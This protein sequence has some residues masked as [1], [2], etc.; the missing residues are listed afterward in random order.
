[1]MRMM[2]KEFSQLTSSSRELNNFSTQPE[3]NP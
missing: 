2:T 1:M 3:V